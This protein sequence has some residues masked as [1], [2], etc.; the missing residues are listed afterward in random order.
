MVNTRAPVAKKRDQGP[1]NKG[2]GKAEKQDVAV[3]DE[4]MPL[5]QQSNESD[6]NQKELM[7]TIA[8]QY[9]GALLSIPDFNYLL[10]YPEEL[11]YLTGSCHL[12]L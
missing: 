5:S 12:G 9:A 2:K 1:T 10:S 11:T 4:D 6:E 7:E 8:K 3:A